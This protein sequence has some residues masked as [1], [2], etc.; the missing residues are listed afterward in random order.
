MSVVFVDLCS[1]VTSVFECDGV[2]LCIVFF[3]K[4]KTAYW[5]RF[6]DW[7]SY[8]CSSDLHRIY[9][10]HEQC[11][12]VSGARCHRERLDLVER[13]Q[14]VVARRALLLVRLG[15]GSEAPRR[16]GEDRAEVVAR[17]LAHHPLPRALSSSAFRPNRSAIF[18][19]RGTVST[20]SRHRP[21]RT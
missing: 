5:L 2:F 6:S 1:D 20:L 12:I 18:M 10:P 13:H 4:Q 11:A 14:V 8:V 9:A 19:A 17:K 15:P 21:R 3:F 16:I 7:S